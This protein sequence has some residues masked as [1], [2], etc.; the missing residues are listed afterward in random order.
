MKAVRAYVRRRKAS[1]VM[2]ALVADGHLQVVAIPVMALGIDLRVESFAFASD[3]ELGYERIMLIELICRDE[4]VED[5]IATIRRAA[6]E[7][8][9]GD[10]A[11]FVMPID[12][13]VRIRDGVRGPGIL[14]RG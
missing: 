13:G 12:I 3:L 2:K 7:D 9:G 14:G 10:G 8:D 5:S 11:I 4:R 1:A 6:H